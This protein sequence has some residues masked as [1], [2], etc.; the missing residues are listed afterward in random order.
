MSVKLTPWFSADVKP[1]HEGVYQRQGE[2]GVYFAYWSIKTNWRAYQPDPERA[3]RFKNI[4]TMYKNLPW[5]GR[6]E[7]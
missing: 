1:V 5:R 7:P 2:D 3:A 4:P 6:V